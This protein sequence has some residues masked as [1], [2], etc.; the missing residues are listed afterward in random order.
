MHYAS[1]QD[2][3]RMLAQVDVREPMGGRDYQLVVMLQHTGLRVSELV[4]L[5]VSDARTH[6]DL[7]ATP[8]VDK[9]HVGLR[10][11]NVAKIKI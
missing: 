8:I 3:E 7:T 9:I 6:V 2:I 10:R 5:D 1:N 11:S 4:G